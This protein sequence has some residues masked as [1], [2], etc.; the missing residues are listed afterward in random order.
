MINIDLHIIIQKWKE[1]ES[2]FKRN[3]QM[4]V[5]P[6]FIDQ[7]TPKKHN[8]NNHISWFKNKIKYNHQKETVGLMMKRSLYY[9]DYGINIGTEI[10]GI[11]PS[12][13]YKN[14]DYK[15]GEDTIAIPI[16]SYTD[17]KSVDTFDIH[18]EKT[19]DNNLKNDSLLKIRQIK[20]ISKKRV[21]SYIGK[22]SDIELKNNIQNKI[23]LMLGMKL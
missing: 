14:N 5:S 19:K 21:Q 17:E 1:I 2:I 11:R 4:Y 16:T 10:N 8:L 18:L 7:E 12:L 23:I 9:V 15:Y 13:I 3:F 22:I 20:M 6:D